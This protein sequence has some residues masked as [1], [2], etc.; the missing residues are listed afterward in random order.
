MHRAPKKTVSFCASVKGKTSPKSVMSK[1]SSHYAYSKR[2]V[3]QRAVTV[4]S[5]I[6]IPGKGHTGTANSKRELSKE[7]AAIIHNHKEKNNNNEFLLGSCRNT[8]QKQKGLKQETDSTDY[9]RT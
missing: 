5:A 4:L 7:E 1:T 9:R 8:K 2:S 6:Q 3:I